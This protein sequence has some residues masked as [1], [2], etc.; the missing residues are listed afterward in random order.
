MKLFAAFQVLIHDV[1]MRLQT[2]SPVWDLLR[3]DGHRIIAV[4]L[5]GSGPGSF[6]MRRDEKRL[7]EDMI[8]LETRSLSLSVSIY[9]SIS[10]SMCISLSLSLP[11]Y[12]S[13]ISISI[14]LALSPFFIS[15]TRNYIQNRHLKPNFCL[16]PSP[17]GVVGW[18]MNRFVLGDTTLQSGNS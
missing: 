17:H 13:S 10:I 18:F 16:H 3:E 7:F 1:K 9:I 15:K 8:G 2:W 14:S 12:P 5:P 6:A 4:D 11:P